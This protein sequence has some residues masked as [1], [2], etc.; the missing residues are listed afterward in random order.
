LVVE[1]PLQV[2]GQLAGRLVTVLWLAIDRLEDDGLEVPRDL[3]IELARRLRHALGH[4]ADEP[5]A[6]GLVEG[7]TK[8][9][10]L[11]NRQPKAVDVAA[12]IRGD[13]KPLGRQIAEGAD[14]FTGL[15]Q[16][17]GA[18]NLGEPEV[19]Q[20]D[21]S[22]EVEEQVRGLDVPVECSLGMGILER[23]GH[24]IADLGQPPPVL[25]V[26]SGEP[27][28]VPLGRRV[29]TDGDA[30]LRVRPG[31]IPRRGSLEVADVEGELRS[32]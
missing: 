31:R 16:V 8:R 26:N 13:R 21:I 28:R 27:A 20:P 10:Q 9:E 22:T 14:D 18:V 23:V 5:V 12:L 19:G 32:R 3:R 29:W 4:L 17:V 11:I 25:A 15:G 30:F 6:T 1:K 24:L 2:L 7:R